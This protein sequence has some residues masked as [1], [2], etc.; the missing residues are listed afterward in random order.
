GAADATH[1]LGG[2]TVSATPSR[3]YMGG[4]GGAGDDDENWGTAGGPGGG[5]ILIY[6]NTII[7]NNFTISARGNNGVTS[8]AGGNSGQDGMG[9][10]GAGGT[11][12]LQAN[13]FNF[14]NVPV[15]ANGGLGG[16]SD[17]AAGTF[18]YHGPGGGGG[19]GL[20]WFS[21]GVTPAGAV[22]S[23]TGGAAGFTRNHDATRS[24]WEAGVGSTGQVDFNFMRNE[25][26]CGLPVTLLL[27]DAI[28]IA[29][30]VKLVWS[31][32]WEKNNAYFIVERSANGNNFSE[33]AYVQGNGSSNTIINYNSWD[34]NP[35]SG[36][37]Y[38]RLKQVDFD[39][40]IFYSHIV[41]VQFEE[42]RYTVSIY[43]NPVKAPEVIHVNYFLKSPEV[44]QVKLYNPEGKEVYRHSAFY[45]NENE[46]N[47]IEIYTFN[48]APGMYYLHIVSE[49]KI[50]IKKII[51]M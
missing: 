21:S 6:A 15:N 50:I 24:N 8:P 23:V 48:F 45:E 5:I 51:V 3:L 39:G 12:A 22:T 26:T 11:I 35:L 47:D 7:N 32:S 33:V 29:E 44:V 38:Y 41:P 16:S 9:G 42:S 19:G 17:P 18:T 1:G 31:T 37:S 40:I 34:S 36:I 25:S 14:T 46:K 28:I 20:I 49:E 4:G 30:K 2:I 27:F 13:T 43:P 10:G